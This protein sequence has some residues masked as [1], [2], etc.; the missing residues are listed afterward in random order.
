MYFMSFLRGSANGEHAAGDGVALDR[1]LSR[2]ATCG[3]PLETD[4]L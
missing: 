2:L 1:W 4:F 3:S